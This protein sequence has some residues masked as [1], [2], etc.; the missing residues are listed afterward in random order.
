[1]SGLK[2]GDVGRAIRYVA[3]TLS[4]GVLPTTAG[5]ADEALFPGLFSPA[6]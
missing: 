2:G 3:N 4:V 6:W 1:M 5:L